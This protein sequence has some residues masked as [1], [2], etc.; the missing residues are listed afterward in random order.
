MTQAE[1]VAEAATKFLAQPDQYRRD[2]LQ[3]AVDEYQASKAPASVNFF[4]RSWIQPAL[5]IQ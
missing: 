2:K 4:P 3:D 5:P 1:R